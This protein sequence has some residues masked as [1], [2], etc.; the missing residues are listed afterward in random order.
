MERLG[1]V[2]ILEE[3]IGAGAQGDVW[4]GRKE[5]SEEPLAF[6]KLRPELARE[7]NVIDAFLKERDTLERVDSPHV[8]RLRDMVTEGETLALVMDYVGGGDL[9]DVIRKQGTLAPG[10]VASYGAAIAAGLSAIHAAGLVHRDVKPANILMDDAATP[11]APRVADF[12]VARI[13][14]SAASTRSTGGSAGTPLYMAPE[15]AD[16]LPAAP[17][18]DIY[19]LGVVLYEMCCGVPPFIGG[20]AALLKSH[21]M[22]DPG[23]P[24]GVPDVLW[25]LI[26]RMMAKDPAARPTADQVGRTLTDAAP[27][28]ADLP[29]APRLSSPPAPVPA[30]AVARTVLGTPASA[31]SAPPFSAP[32]AVSASTATLPPPAS[33]PSAVS[34]STVTLPPFS[35]PPAPAMRP[36]GPV[37][38]PSGV[39]VD[40]SAAPGGSGASAK[41]DEGENGKK[42]GKKKRSRGPIVALVLILAIALVAAGAI[43]ANYVQRL[44]GNRP[45][46]EPSQVGPA[47]TSEA[48]PSETPSASDDATARASASA[49]ASASSSAT[50]TTMPDLVGLTVDQ[51]KAK[52]PGNVKVTVVKANAPNGEKEGTVLSTDPAAGEKIPDAVT[53]TVAG[54][55]ASVAMKT[56]YLSDLKQLD[57]FNGFEAKAIEM[58]GK[59]YAHAVVT[60][61][62]SGSSNQI[63]RTTEW[64]L[65]RYFSTLNGTIGITDTSKEA[66]AT[67]T[68]DFYID[69][70]LVRSETLQFG[71]FKDI[72]LDVQNGL[73]LKIVVTRTDKNSDSASVGFGDFQL[74][75]DPDKVPSLDDLNKNN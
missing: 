74:Q 69:Q 5:G 73:R 8:V 62:Y 30:S 26:G 44:F 32:S 17:S 70:V 4:K 42:K 60:T 71:E 13:C 25:D 7:R 68:V 59:T 20:P 27:G 29:A 37:P 72:S 46:A 57:S 14:D 43:G 6:K 23:R 64:N 35:V 75:G 47:P 10:L 48:P 16:G 12:G 63:T 51:A 3:R 24:D 66:D 49:S 45:V 11:A 38:P 31:P 54:S 67:F 39:A 41:S 19:S 58:S 65:G 21:M 22:M 33:A 56:V 40:R 9:A 52:L 1:S 53:L 28:L 55:A 2:Y 18:M 50:A 34:A 61:V 36:G 15:V